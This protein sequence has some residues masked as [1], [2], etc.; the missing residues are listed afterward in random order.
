[1]SLRSEI[2]A[3]LVGGPQS[4]EEMLAAIPSA[5]GDGKRLAGNMY[6]LATEGKVRRAGLSDNKKI[7]Y[8]LE[9]SVWPA[10]E[11]AAEINASDHADAAPAAGQGKRKHAAQAKGRGTGS[12][13]RASH[14]RRATAAKPPSPPRAQRPAAKTARKPARGHAA[15]KRTRQ[16]AAALDLRTVTNDYLPKLPA[17]LRGGPRGRAVLDN[18]GANQHQVGGEHY[19]ALDPQP[20]DVIEAWGLGFLAGNVVKYIARCGRKPDAAAIEDLRKARHYLDKLIERG[21]AEV[22]A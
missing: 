7:I 17:S 6:V 4:V 3:A 19:R 9:P 15:G 22:G 16:P 2:R 1:M 13:K 5:E 14:D 8:A 21:A 10:K 20:W 12:P 18:T 11:P